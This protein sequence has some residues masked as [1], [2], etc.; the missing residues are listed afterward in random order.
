MDQ[1]VQQAA[2]NDV[3]IETDRDRHSHHDEDEDSEYDESGRHH[4]KEKKKK[5][6]KDKKAVVAKVKAAAAPPSVSTQLPHWQDVI[7]MTTRLVYQQRSSYSANADAQALVDRD[8]LLIFGQL[9]L[10]SVSTLTYFPCRDQYGTNTVYPRAVVDK[11]RQDRYDFLSRTIENGPRTALRAWAPVSNGEGPPAALKRFAKMHCPV[12]SHDEY[13]HGNAQLVK[14]DLHSGTNSKPRTF[15]LCNLCGIPTIDHTKSVCCTRLRNEC[16]PSRSRSNDNQDHCRD[17]GLR[18]AAHALSH[19]PHSSQPVADDDNNED[20]DN[21]ANND[22]RSNNNTG[23]SSGS[24]GNSGST[25]APA[26]DST[27]TRGGQSS[28]N[29]HTAVPLLHCAANLTINH[30]DVL[31]AAQTGNV[32]AF[33]EAAL[34]NE[35]DTIDTANK[36]NIIYCSL[37]H[38]KLN[39]NSQISMQHTGEH[40]TLCQSEGK[41]V[42]EGTM[43]GWNLMVCQSGRP[44][45]QDY[46]NRH[47]DRSPRRRVN[48]GYSNAPNDGSHSSAASNR[49][50]ASHSSAHSLY[51]DRHSGYS[52]LSSV[53][54]DHSLQAN[55]DEVSENYG[56]GSY[57]SQPS[58]HG[59]GRSHSSR[60]RSQRRS[61]PPNND[62]DDN[63]DNGRDDDEDVDDGDADDDDDDDAQSRP[64]SPSPPPPHRQPPV[65]GVIGAPPSPPPSPHPSNSVGASSASSA[66]SSSSYV[67]TIAPSSQSGQPVVPLLPVVAPA[68]CRMSLEQLL[69]LNYPTPYC[70]NCRGLTQDH[71]SRPLATHV[72][73]NAP[74]AAATAASDA[75]RYKMP[76]DSI[77][78]V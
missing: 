4:V 58:S 11:V 73:A 30:E 6:K 48:D 3:D 45:A 37:S 55:S 18:V 44:P 64:Q 10:T 38:P 68:N 15:F 46:V 1:E 23:S 8:R 65:A 34:Y 39:G 66:P 9:T 12:K 54:S 22:S 61:P 36:N 19:L 40:H 29:T 62:G 63:D 17:C 25:A 78:Q 51:S 5:I 57:H 77:P 67:P 28:V 49:S 42:D 31:Q 7:D 33:L 41:L 43:P 13:I 69:G 47:R 35:A 74:L 75:A 52:R 14:I 71:P 50:V 2:D 24:G 21:N 72:V 56:V 27:N 59:S 20:G 16:T 32:L 53:R 26:P 76:L 70:F 60:S